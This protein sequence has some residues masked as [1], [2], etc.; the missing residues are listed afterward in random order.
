MPAECSGL[1]R[2]LTI[3]LGGFHGMAEGVSQIERGAH[4]T[5]PLI[6]AHHLSFVDAGPLDSVRHG[7]Q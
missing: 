4:A 1:G 3:A 5:F 7:L 6:L 2:A